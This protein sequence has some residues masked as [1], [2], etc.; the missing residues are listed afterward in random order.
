MPITL[1]V[2]GKFGGSYA[3]SVDLED[4][5]LTTGSMILID[6]NHPFGGFGAGPDSLP[7][8]G[9]NVVI[10]NAAWK[11]FAALPDVNMAL[12]DATKLALAC[13]MPSNLTAAEAVWERTRC[14]GVHGAI[15][16]T[17]LQS[18]HTTYIEPSLIFK[19][20]IRA[21]PNHQYFMSCEGIVTRAAKL[22]TDGRNQPLC[23]VFDTATAP[24][25]SYFNFMT[26]GPTGKNL[27]DELVSTMDPP[28]GNVEGV[29][30]LRTAGSWRP[31]G[32]SASDATMGI[33]AAV[34]GNPNPFGAAFVSGAPSYIFH[35]FYLENLTLSGREADEVDAIA[36]R[37]HARNYGPGGKYYG[38]TTS[39]PVSGF[40][41]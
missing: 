7:L 10:T 30:F 39:K 13:G 14:K 5:I 36:R 25:N 9:G 23:G 41:N 34:W 37:I 18:G 40:V 17:A 21:R 20:F 19:N 26:M 3:R 2:A 33:W 11:K 8:N 4:E 27:G 6:V 24:P 31:N 22:S 12:T 16:Q 28:G 35:R 1:D 29:P 32:V 15:T 38:D